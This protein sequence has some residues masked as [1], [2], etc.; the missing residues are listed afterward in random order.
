MTWNGHRPPETIA[1]GL[2]PRPKAF[3]LLAAAS[4]SNK[5]SA[6]VLRWSLRP[7]VRVSARPSLRSAHRP[8]RS[9]RVNRRRC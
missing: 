4:L 7:S 1:G 2:F 9:W 5:P 8:E 3:G 6:P